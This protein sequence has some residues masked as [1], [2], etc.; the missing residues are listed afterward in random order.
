M[1]KIGELLDASLSKREQARLLLRL[2]RSILA[3]EA[4][5]NDQRRAT[6]KTSRDRRRAR[7]ARGLDEPVNE[8]NLQRDAARRVLRAPTV[9]GEQTD[10]HEAAAARVKARAPGRAAYW[11]FTG[12]APECTPGDT[13]TAQRFYRKV[14]AAIEQ[15]GWT[16]SE[17]AALYDL[18][19]KWGPRARGT[20]PRFMI[21]GTK[22]GRLDAAAEERIRIL[23]ERM[24]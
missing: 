16:R 19:K 14:L 8:F 3:E 4:K 17:R 11:A 18:E 1:K 5:I 15:G 23:K 24:P 7:L 22:G 6:R 9:G 12:P 20:D 2:K 13:L 21:A 10:R